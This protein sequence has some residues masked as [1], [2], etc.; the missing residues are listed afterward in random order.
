MSCKRGALTHLA[1][2]PNLPTGLPRI[3]L[4]ELTLAE[5]RVDLVGKV[6]DADLT[7]LV[8]VGP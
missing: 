1:P 4:H 5:A 6:D 3:A 8:R 7:G 2:E